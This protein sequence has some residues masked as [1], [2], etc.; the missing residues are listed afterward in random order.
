MAVGSACA[1]SV[2]RSAGPYQSTTPATAAES[3]SPSSA[4]R[5]APADSPQATT[6]VASTPSSSARA[7]SKPA[8]ASDVVELGGE[9]R[10]ADSR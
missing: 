3:V 2:V 10:S 5:W 4:A 8:A 9:H 1:A 6:R 7:R